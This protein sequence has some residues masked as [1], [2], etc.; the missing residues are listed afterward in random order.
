MADKDLVIKEKIA[1]S[2]I[3]DFA[4][5]YSYAHSWFVE[6]GYGVV[7]E[8]Y[9]EKVSGNKK[10]IYIEWSCK[11]EISDYFNIEFKLK[12]FINGLS[13]VEVEIDGEKKEMNKGNVLIEI[14]GILT[15]DPKSK[16]DTTPLY[17]FM[18]DVYNKYVIP[19]RVDALENKTIGDVQTFKDELKAFL[20]L[21]GK[22]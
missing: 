4:A 21:S 6:E 8:K 7:E 9:S 3:W 10:N 1:H 13:D 20:E 18:R 2:G 5:L 15:K 22:R 17:K 11:K 14:K 12:F 16:W 19:A